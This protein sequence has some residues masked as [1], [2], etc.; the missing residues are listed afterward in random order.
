MTLEHENL[1]DSM[2]RHRDD[3]QPF[4]LAT[5][6]RTED[7]TAGNPG[8]KAIIRAD[9]TVI[10]WVGGGCTLG[11]VKKAAAAA[12]EDGRPRLIRV[13]PKDMLEGETPVE[14]LELHGSSCPSRGTTEVFI[15]PILRRP[16]LLVVGTS[17]VAKSLVG[18]AKPLGYA[19]TVAGAA[20]DLAAFDDADHRI[21]NLDP[22]PDDAPSFHFVVV[23]TQGKRDR[24]SLIFG[25]STGAG[26]VAFV[27]SKGKAEKIK[28]DLLE[29]GLDP[30]RIAAVR[31]PAGLEI[32]AETAD[33]IALSIFADMVREKRLGKDN[34]SGRPGEDGPKGGPYPRLAGAAP[35]RE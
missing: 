12:L 15:D 5:V 30:E 11:A 1:I 6:V 24:D 14:G 9:G 32:G 33:E 28:S 16:S 31:S 29:A 34:S 20:E 7:S 23:A 25:L 35:G 2:I 13:K 22:L 4:V 10:G 8:D 3:D 27:G 19:V 26:Y 21:D 17:P 18:L